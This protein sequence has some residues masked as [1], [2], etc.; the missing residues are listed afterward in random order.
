LP[1][2]F[3]R[4]FRKEFRKKSPAMQAAI[5]ETLKR[6]ED[7]DPSPGL[8]KKKMTGHA[9]VYEASVDMG[10]RVTFEQDGDTITMRANCNHD[11]LQRP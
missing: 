10:T 7:G 4:R 9:G 5:L 1:V 2:Q 11:I 3:S 8:R 6:L